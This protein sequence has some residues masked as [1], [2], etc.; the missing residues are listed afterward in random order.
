M[1]LSCGSWSRKTFIRSGHRTGRFDARKNEV[2]L[3]WRGDEH[4]Q[5]RG[6]VTVAKLNGRNRKTYPG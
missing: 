1:D 5:A 3:E 6:Y 2:Y 4:L